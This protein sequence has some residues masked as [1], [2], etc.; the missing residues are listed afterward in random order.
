MQ[1]NGNFLSLTNK[2]EVATIITDSEKQISVG[3]CYYVIQAM[4][5]E[6]EKEKKSIGSIL[7]SYDG[8][9]CSGWLL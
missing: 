4:E 1:K 9:I 7:I 8:S 2:F 5:K 3:T 6:K